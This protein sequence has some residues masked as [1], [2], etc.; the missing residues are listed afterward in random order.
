MNTGESGRE[1]D[2]Q[3]WTWGKRRERDLGTQRWTPEGQG[4]RGTERCT[5]EGHGGSVIWVL[6][7]ALQGFRV[8]LCSR[9]ISLF[10]KV[11]HFC[12][13]KKKALT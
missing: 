4:G 10:L 7:A 5:R 6:T 11:S 9:Q 2:T 12:V 1:R 13:L 8:L 3:R